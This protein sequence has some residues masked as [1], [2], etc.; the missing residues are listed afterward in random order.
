MVRHSSGEVYNSFD[1][2]I[3]PDLSVETWKQLLKEELDNREVAV[4]DIQAT[5]LSE[6]YGV[7]TAEGII[8][9]TDLPPSEQPSQLVI[10]A[11][12]FIALTTPPTQPQNQ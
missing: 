12:G 8:I 11:I 7:E 1:L 6:Q 10:D 2:P 9:D 3:E 5:Q 4:N